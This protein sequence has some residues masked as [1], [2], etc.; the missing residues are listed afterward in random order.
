M[1][2]GSSE[3]LIGWNSGKTTYV[4]LLDRIEGAW[5]LATDSVSDHCES[6][7]YN[8]GC[9]AGA[10]TLS[11]RVYTECQLPLSGVHSIMMEKL[12]QP[13]EGG[14]C[15]PFTF[16]L[17]TIT[18]KV[19]VYTPAEREDTLPLFLLHLYMYSVLLALPQP[20]NLV[21]LFNIY[22][23]FSSSIIFFII[24][25]KGNVRIQKNVFQFKKTKLNNFS[26]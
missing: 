8:L 6:S 10:C 26:I 13:G 24:W 11:H 12:A 15:T 7:V 22:V 4:P 5:L 14:K 19:V 23:F 2:T 3:I 25:D 1:Q 16:T 9:V 21:Y 17:S 20:L 18:Y